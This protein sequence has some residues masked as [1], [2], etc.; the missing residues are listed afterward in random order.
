[1]NAKRKIEVFSAGG[2]VR[3]E[4][5]SRINDLACPSCEVVI[6]DVKETGVAKRAKEMGIQSVPAVAI[7]GKLANCC[8]GRGP[9][10]AVLRAAG[11]FLT[12]PTP[13]QEANPI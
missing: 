10:E 3:E 4:T 2:P 13:A 5:I 12:T 7:D 9:D 1:M 11:L 8:S 6:L